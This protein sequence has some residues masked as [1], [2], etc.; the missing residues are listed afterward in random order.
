MHNYGRTLF[1]RIHPQGDITVVMDV[2][3]LDDFAD[4]AS[5]F[6]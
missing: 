3:R 2:R 1:I 6:A 5:F 4:V